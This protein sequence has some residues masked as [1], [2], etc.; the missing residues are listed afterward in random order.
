MKCN[1]QSK[2]DKLEN[3]YFN[4]GRDDSTLGHC[5]RCLHY[6]FIASSAIKLMGSLNDSAE[7]IIEKANEETKKLL[8]EKIENLKKAG[9][10]RPLLK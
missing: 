6:D 1:F 8:E 7:D 3:N 2:L 9:L 10:S 5:F 4:N